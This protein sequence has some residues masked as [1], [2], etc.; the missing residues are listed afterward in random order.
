MNRL[1]QYCTT[2]REGWR[3]C[4]KEMGNLTALQDS[5]AALSVSIEETMLEARRIEECVVPAMVQKNEK[6]LEQSKVKGEAQLVANDRQFTKNVNR[7]KAQH[8]SFA[9]EVAQ[10]K[11]SYNPVQQAADEIRNK[12]A[13]SANQVQYQNL[14]VRMSTDS[15]AIDN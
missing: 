10:N 2:S 9:Q 13:K 7:L 4:E 12:L 1:Y 8:E 11:S 5:I 6:D 3:E 14:D 15:N